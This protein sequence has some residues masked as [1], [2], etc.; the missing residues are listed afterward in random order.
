MESIELMTIAHTTIA[1]G[2]GELSIAITDSQIVA[3]ER[4]V[5][6]WG[7]RRTNP[8]T[9]DGMFLGVDPIAFTTSDTN[10]LFDVFHLHSSDVEKVIRTIPSIDRSFNVISDPFNLLIFWL[11]HLAPI[12]IKDIKVC[13]E[14]QMN[15]LRLWHYKIFCSVVNNSFKHGVNRGVMEA[16]INTLT[17]KSD[18]VRLE[19]WRRL[20]DSH[21]EKI[22]DPT[23]RF[24][25]YIITASPDDMF[26]RAISENQ[27]ALRSKIVTIARA[28]YEVHASGDRVGS[29]SSVAENA[30]GEKIIAQAASIIDSATAAL[31]SEVLNPNMFINDTSVRDVANLFTTISDR[32]LKTTLLKINEVAVLQTGSRTFDKVSKSPEGMI[33]IGVRSLIVEIIRSMVSICREKRVNM[34]VHAE[35]F[36]TM[37]DIYT[38]SRNTNEDILTVKRSIGHLIDPF[39]ITSNPA[40]Q[41]TLRLAVIYYIIL[42]AIL[43]LR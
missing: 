15:L 11:C 7:L 12:Y 27:T 24:L 34:G 6:H 18:I 14:F 22:L 41:S 23:D 17:R 42:R 3:I 20:I 26:L 21:C 13:H 36:K 9:L 31:V 8:L 25:K 33:Y 5:I 19:S 38:A 10:A 16:T 30:E 37:R 28:Y 32:M 40:S 2:F 39:N 43:K 4:M 1:S 35:V 29:N